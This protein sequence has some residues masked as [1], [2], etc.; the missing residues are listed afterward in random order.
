MATLKPAD[1][2]NSEH[3][4]HLPSPDHRN[5]NHTPRKQAPPPADRIPPDPGPLGQRGPTEKINV[6]VIGTGWIANLSH[7][8]SLSAFAD[9]HP[10]V[11]LRAA[12]DIDLDRA[13]AFSERFGFEHAY[14]DTSEML[15]TEE[16]QAVYVL[17]PERQM[18]RV[19]EI[20]LDLGIPALIEKPPGK[21]PEQVERLIRI[22]TRTGT[23]HFVA[24]NRRCMPLVVS[25]QNRMKEMRAETGSIPELVSFLFSRHGRFDADFSTT[26]VHA[27]D[28]ISFLCQSRYQSLRMD[29]HKVS[30]Q[31][32]C[33]GIFIFGELE[34]GTRISLEILP[35]AGMNCE[36]VDVH[37]P[38]RTLNLAIPCVNGADGPGS[39]REYHRGKLISD[40]Q[41]NATPSYWNDGFYHETERFLGGLLNGRRQFPGYDLASTL[42]SAEIMAAIANRSPEYFATKPAP[43]LCERA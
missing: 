23:P 43:E 33:E 10:S 35:D 25:L 18:A 2:N 13:Q 14:G 1:S 31:R 7:G 4:G 27:I 22:A 41:G 9:A 17:V 42:Q 11:C 34:S 32:H 40:V 16:L 29:Y 15:S 37:F 36:R 21:T 38:A 19:A 3:T 8:P 26:A 28:A 39:I 30:E 24:F 20:P 12:C 5:G 6:G